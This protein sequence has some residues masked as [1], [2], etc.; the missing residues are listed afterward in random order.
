MDKTRHPRLS[1][2]HPPQ[3]PSSSRPRR[4]PSY[5]PQPPSSQPTESSSSTHTRRERAQRGARRIQ[6]ELE[7]I[8][9]QSLLFVK[10]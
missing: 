10:N 9:G 4:S 1:P 2:S 7:P 6:E 8:L 5:P 3:P